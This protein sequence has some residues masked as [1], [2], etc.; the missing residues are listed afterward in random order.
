M[1]RVPRGCDRLVAGSGTEVGWARWSC[2]GTAERA[3]WIGSRNTRAQVVATNRR[4]RFAALDSYHGLDADPNARRPT[5][6]RGVLAEPPADSAHVRD[7]Q[8]PTYV[9]MGSGLALAVGVIL[10]SVS[11]LAV[12]AVCGWAVL[13]GP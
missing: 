2:C 8:V 9:E 10:V 6:R 3:D 11:M 12:A 7:T 1:A 4:W 5:R 13:A